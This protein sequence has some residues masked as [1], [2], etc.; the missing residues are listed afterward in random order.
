M[1]DKQLFKR[2][3]FKYIET[4]NIVAANYYPV[5]TAIAVRDTNSTHKN[6]RQV[7]I[8]NDRSQGGTAGLRS[9]ASI[10][11]M[12]QRRH[13][14]WD[15]YGLIEP[16]NDLDQWGRGVMTPASYY[17]LV[18]DTKTNNAKAGQAQQRSVQRKLEQPLLFFYSHS[19]EKIPTFNATSV[20]VVNFAQAKSPEIPA[21]SSNNNSQ[22]A[23]NST[24]A[25][26]AASEANW[27]FKSSPTLKATVFGVLPNEI[28][29]RIINLEDRF[30]GSSRIQHID[31]N[32]FAKEFYL[33]AN[34]HLDQ[35]IT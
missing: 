31:L 6:Q 9:N 2:K 29:V 26:F 14:T 7:T 18:H 1:V 25:T 3:E 13:K 30:D 11:L 24:N 32:T 27:E 16:L 8:L 17:M 20:P 12:M 15:T 22:L 34:Q 33:E 28:L 35:N 5:T 21:Q 10:E 19:F 4:K 23:A